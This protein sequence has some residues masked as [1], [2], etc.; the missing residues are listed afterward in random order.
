MIKQLN[1]FLC[2]HT[3]AFLLQTYFNEITGKIRNFPNISLQFLFKLHID[4]N[5]IDNISVRELCCIIIFL[6]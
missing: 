2:S 5:T 1:V 6:K 4:H 3:D